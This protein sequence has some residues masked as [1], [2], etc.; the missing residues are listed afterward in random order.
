MSEASTFRLNERQS[1]LVDGES[2]NSSV[3]C[4]VKSFDKHL[5]PFRDGAEINGIGLTRTVG[6][7]IDEKV[8]ARSVKDFLDPI[9]K[10]LVGDSRQ[11]RRSIKCDVLHTRARQP[12]GS[13]TIKT[14]GMRIAMILILVGAHLSLCACRADA[15]ISPPRK[16]AIKYMDLHVERV[17]AAMNSDPK[18]VKHT[19]IWTMSNPAGDDPRVLALCSEIIEKSTNTTSIW[20]AVGAVGGVI[21]AH[22]RFGT[23]DKR[24]KS[25]IASVLRRALK[26][27]EQRTSF[28]A[29]RQLKRLGEEYLDVAFEFYLQ[30]LS[31]PSLE[32]DPNRRRRNYIAAIRELIEFGRPQAAAA[33]RRITEDQELLEFYKL[34]IRNIKNP[35]VKR[36]REEFIKRWKTAISTEGKQR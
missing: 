15:R 33:I 32:A 34:Q 4:S 23:L 28:H 10:P 27:Q 14:A 18:E 26:I 16:S 17:R 5:R 8:F 2:R 22:K 35:I 30:Y 31:T 3:T 1:R 24:R 19:L 6:V 7:R 11:S 29:A 13:R 20:H 36:E 9:K 25:E 12:L 21:D